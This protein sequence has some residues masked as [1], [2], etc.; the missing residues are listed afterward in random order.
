MDAAR[1][2]ESVGERDE[3]PNERTLLKKRVRRSLWGHTRRK[4]VAVNWSLTVVPSGEGA[5]KAAA[6][7]A[8]AAEGG[9]TTA[10]EPVMRMKPCGGGGGHAGALPWGDGGG[11]DRL[12]I[13]VSCVLT[14]VG[15]ECER[16]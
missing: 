15:V 14:D 12:D 10:P 7:A 13:A 1:T 3:Q 4:G 8:F 5:R 11:G 6:A 16:L 9:E 2:G